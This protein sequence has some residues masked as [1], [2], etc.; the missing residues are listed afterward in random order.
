M[1]CISIRITTDLNRDGEFSK[2]VK[3]VETESVRK[4]EEEMAGG[5][6]YMSTAAGRGEEGCD[7][8]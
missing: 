4:E 7:E 3:V 2:E 1:P 8:T 5:R 6:I